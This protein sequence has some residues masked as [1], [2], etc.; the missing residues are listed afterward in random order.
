METS[1]SSTQTE[2]QH[3]CCPSNDQNGFT[4]KHE[5]MQED[6]KREMTG[7]N[8]ALEETSCSLAFGTNSSGQSSPVLAPASPGLALD[9]QTA[10]IKKVVAEGEK[11]ACTDEDSHYRHP[12]GH[13]EMGSQDY[14]ALTTIKKEARFELRAFQEE[15]K[16]SKLF[17]CSS[18]KEPIRVKKVRDSEE[19]EELERE[20]RELIHSQAVKKNPG[21]ATKWWNPPVIKTIEEELDPD[22]L[23]SH[24]K[25]QERKQKRLESSNEQ[26]ELPTQ[27]DVSC[28]P[29]AIEEE[30]FPEEQ[31]NFSITRSQH[32]L[33]E[34]TNVIEALWTQT[35]P[36][37][38]FQTLGGTE[39]TPVEKPVG[40]GL[41]D[42]ELSSPNSSCHTEETDSG[43]D[44]LS[45]QS[46]DTATQE[47]LSNDV[48]VDNVSDSG[49][50]NEAT[51][52][53]LENSLRDFSLPTTPQAT[54]PIDCE[55][56]RRSTVQSESSMSPSS[57]EASSTGE[58]R[59]YCTEV[60]DQSVT[61]MSLSTW[62]ESQKKSLEE[63]EQVHCEPRFG[64]TLESSTVKSFTQQSPHIYDNRSQCTPPQMLTAVPEM[65]LEVQE[66]PVK[67]PP[68]TTDTFQPLTVSGKNPHKG[69]KQDFSY[70]S[71]YSEAAELRSTASLTRPREKGVSCGPFRLRSHKQGTLSMIEEEIRAA[72]EREQEL[73]KQ[74]QTQGQ[75]TTPSYKERPANVP[76]R[77][78][79]TA[80]SAPGKIHC[81]TI[82]PPSQ[83]FTSSPTPSNA[84]SEGSEGGHRPKNLM[85]TLMDD[86]EVH[87]VKCKEKMEDN[88]V[89]E[90]TRVTRQKSNMAVRWEAGVYTNQEVDEE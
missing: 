43:L 49:A 75:D 24:R 54:S 29:E 11:I 57:L 3:I 9:I 30:G 28:I 27:T 90:A 85:Q 80:K 7:I 2:S 19:M 72:Q 16:P 20:R 70:F 42:P 21:I 61:S 83:D 69:E 15:K 32:K 10:L 51:N 8:K 1:F 13:S 48:S 66:V 47:L 46:Q 56:S 84:S 67:A 64:E 87:K 38:C 33:E 59:D 26:Q 14:K 25:Y 36:E 50:S 35:T 81:I 53:C 5:S 60:P 71:K 40:I 39:A 82:S 79:V 31:N 12:N 88:K 73:K 55:M 78:V 34:K 76:T 6:A 65:R 4:N 86:Y 23:E 18:E 44:D 77:L 45:V 22:Q 37:P 62:T 89:L 17:D 58:P 74:R 41:E 52:A 63:Y 68:L